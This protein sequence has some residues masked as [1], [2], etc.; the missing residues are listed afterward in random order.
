[1]TQHAHRAGMVAIIGRP[2]V[3]K[4]TLLNRLVGMKLSITS[5]R[6]QTTRHRIIGIVSEPDVQLVFVDTPGFQTRHGGALNKI[7]NR[8]VTDTLQGIDVV[9]LVVEALRFGAEDRKLLALLPPQLPAI[10]V[11]NKIDLVGEKAALLPFIEQVGARHEFAEIV[12]ASA[13]KGTQVG[14][15]AEAIKRH[16]PEAPRI[17]DEDQVTDRSERF[18]AGELVREKV[19]RLLGDELPYAA[20]AVVEKFEQEGNLRRIHASI[21]VDKPGH[22]AIVIGKAGQKLK[23]IGTQARMDMEKLF[24]G[25]VYLELWVRVKGGWADSQ[26]ALKSLG[27]E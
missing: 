3:G 23:Q 15:L 20:T 9:L 4:S 24:G 8:A 2:N 14:R 27:Y 22:K 21:V 1:M 13:A 10:L 26:R 7:M 5:S 17:Y 12:P 19:F 16:L 18:L 25:K 6:P 11:I